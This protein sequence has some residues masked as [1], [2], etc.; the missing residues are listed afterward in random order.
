M[1]TGETANTVVSAV[2]R[3]KG[4]ATAKIDSNPLKSFCRFYLFLPYSVVQTR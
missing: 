2:L 3:V 4:A 1:Q